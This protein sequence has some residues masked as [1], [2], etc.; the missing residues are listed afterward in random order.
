VLVGE[1]I[2]NSVMQEQA[3]MD[4]FDDPFL[5]NMTTESF[6]QIERIMRKRKLP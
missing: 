2:E 4:H 1:L 6:E 5:T 3:T